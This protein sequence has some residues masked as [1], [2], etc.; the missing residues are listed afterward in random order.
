MV[1]HAL[2]KH[3]SRNPEIWG[4]MTG[5]MKTWNNQA[6]KHFREISRGPGEFKQVTENGISFL[7]KRLRDGRGVRLNMNSTFKGFID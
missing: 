5:S 1:G 6:M 2:S 7:E 3:A 4:K